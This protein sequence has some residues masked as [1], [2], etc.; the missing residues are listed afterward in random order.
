MVLVKNTKEN[1]L[2]ASSKNFHQIWKYRIQV[3]CNDLNISILVIQV[4]IMGFKIV[5]KWKLLKIDLITAVRLLI[6]NRG[7]GPKY[8]IIII[9]AQ[10]VKFN[11]LTFET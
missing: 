7:L 6:I 5:F 3:I 10:V 9:K 8:L 4:H 1:Y 2:W 11:L